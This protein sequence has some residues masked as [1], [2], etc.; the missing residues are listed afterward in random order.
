MSTRTGRIP[1][2]SLVARPVDTTSSGS[3]DCACH[4]NAR[5]K[6]QFSGS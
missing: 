6:Q 1:A 3:L 2:L 5:T 4:D